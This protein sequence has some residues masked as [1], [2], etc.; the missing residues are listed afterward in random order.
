VMVSCTTA[1]SYLEASSHK[2]GAAAELAASNKVVMYAGLSSQGE[3]V[4]TAV[5][6]YRP[7]NRD[8]SWTA[9]DWWRRPGMFEYLRFCSNGF[10]LWCNDLTVLLYDDFVGDS[11]PE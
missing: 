7:I 11:R 5:E 9:G 3:F 4:L 10:L 1:N 6:S 2:A 8:V